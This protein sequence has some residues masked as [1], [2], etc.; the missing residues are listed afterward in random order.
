MQQFCLIID[1]GSQS[2]DQP[3]RIL[4][5][6]EPLIVEYIPVKLLFSVLRCL[7]RH[8]EFISV[9]D[10][11][12]LVAFVVASSR[13]VVVGPFAQAHPAEL[14][15]T[16]LAGY[17][18]TAAVFLNRSPAIWRRAHFRVCHNPGEVLAL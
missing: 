17:M 18:V 5:V 3:L 7:V 16:D 14:V 15:L 10:R 8:L 9:F 6:L 1:D 2:P 11:F 13:L 4:M 12:I